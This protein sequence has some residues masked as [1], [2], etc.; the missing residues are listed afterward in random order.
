M[1]KFIIT[2]CIRPKSK[3]KSNKYQRK[4]DNGTISAVNFKLCSKEKP[5]SCQLLN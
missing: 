3:I 4:E 1:W 2:E 5:V